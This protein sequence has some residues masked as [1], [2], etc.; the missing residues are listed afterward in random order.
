MK[1]KRLALLGFVFAT[2]AVLLVAGCSTQTPSSA[3]AQPSAAAPAISKSEAVN[4]LLAQITE[5][6]AALTTLSADFAYT[7]TSTRRQQ[8]ITGKVRLMKP[9]FARI[10]F[11]SIAEP[12]FPNIV[13]SD[14]TLLTTFTPANYRPSSSFSPPAPSVDFVGGSNMSDTVY[15]SPYFVAGPF[16]PV[17]AARGASGLAADGGSFSTS[18]VQR[19]GSNI[20]LWDSILIQSFFNPTAALRFLYASS[21]DDYR[22]EAPQTINGTSHNVLYHRF[23]NGQIEGGDHSVFNQRL[24][25]AANGIIHRYVLD[26]TADKK[27]GTQIMEF[28]N[29][30][31]NEPMTKESFAF[32]PPGS[33]KTDALR[34]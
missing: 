31:T 17:A 32:V 1:T 16:D 2:G 4:A 9:N 14:G 21:S 34:R 8:R 24:Y 30:K 20:R 33:A 15:R 7:V 28:T 26:F 6:N 11:D 18:R 10:T 5:G 23:A 27:P 25:V 29:I 22:V 12:A 3:P 19:D 13:A